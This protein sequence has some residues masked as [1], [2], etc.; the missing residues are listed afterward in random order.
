[1]NLKNIISK[2][3]HKPEEKL[4]FFLAI[5]IS[6]EIVK[7]AL[8]TVKSGQTEVVKIGSLQDWDGK[9]KESLLT[10]I[11]NSISD[12]CDSIETEPEGI[13]FGLPSL[14]VKKEA[15]LPE[16]KEF[17][18]FICQKLALRPLGFVVN[19]EAL[20]SFLK[21][22]EGT[23]VNAIFINLQD[24]ESE[25]SLVKVG[26]ILA[27]ERVGRSQDLAADVQ[28]GL[29]RF[30]KQEDLPARMILFNGRGNLEEY[31]EQLVSFE[32]SKKLSFLHFP[33]VESL[34][35][36]KSIEAI[37]LAGGAEVAK[38]LGFDIREVKE[39]K[40]R[41]A[42]EE[43]EIKE[44]KT[45]ETPEGEETLAASLGFVQNQ[46]ITQIKKEPAIEIGSEKSAEEAFPKD[47]PEETAEPEKPPDTES[48]S[49]VKK[50]ALVNKFI[51]L[52]KKLKLN[53]KLFSLAGKKRFVLI[54]ILILGTTALAGVTA[55]FWYLPKAEVT[56]FLEP[57]LI[58]KNLKIIADK[59]VDQ[60]DIEQQIIPIEE[61]DIILEDKKNA[62]TT[63]E[64]LVGDQAY[65]E[66][67]LY[68]KTE[69]EKNFPQGTI[70]VGPD[71][72]EFTLDEEVVV[73]S[74]S[75]EETEDGE[76]IIYG[77]T[78]VKAKATTIGPESNLGGGTSFSL[79]DYSEK[80]FSAKTESGFS[81]GTSRKVKIVS[82]Q[83]LDSLQ[84][85]LTSKLE[86]KANQELEAELEEDKIILSHKLQPEILTK[87]FNA[88]LDDEVDSLTLDLKIKFTSLLASKNDL[89]NILL[90]L[91]QDELKGDYV[92]EEDKINIE[93]QAI[94]FGEE[95]AEIESLTTVY[96]LPQIDK[97]EVIKN[98]V[99]R[100]PEDTQAFLESLPSFIE[101]EMQ[102]KPNFFGLVKRLPRLS[103]NINLVLKQKE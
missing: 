89:K 100:K 12:A 97:E 44:E 25:I 87:N 48:E 27:S 68:N 23:P 84:E 62:E 96:L 2:F 77:K 5:E 92:L 10:S 31:Q 102:I 26:K 22:K 85:N 78:T 50:E 51:A 42:K 57:K 16:K 81:G 95:K 6:E 72:L 29:A 93:A 64:K 103:K 17:L 76:K 35:K 67:I 40:T 30:K 99:G 54:F 13:I 55:L 38:S 90:N 4:K 43:K 21:N 47:A 71:D 70:L 11:D 8:W 28:E 60:L 65:G 39:E 61:K 52:I 37:A 24:A 18:K 15:I 3:G 74:S 73:A 91:I 63:G 98:L 49:F 14:W 20:V 83:D 56:L 45:I 101:A 1:M 9:T 82:S 7:S 33:K 34:E 80:Q 94:S 75:S 79:K 46:D 32:W 36:E 88:D 19:L 53:L 69:V 59:S 86:E 41:E 58:E 66:I